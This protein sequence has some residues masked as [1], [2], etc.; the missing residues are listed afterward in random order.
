MPEYSYALDQAELARYDAMAARALEHE[1]DLWDTAGIITGAAV[2]DLGCGPGAFLAALATRTA[3]SGTVVG[4]DAAGPAIA[5]AQALVDQRS[6]SGRVRIVHAGAQHTGLEPASFDVVFIRNLLV[7]NGPA[8]GAILGHA[9][10]LLRPGGH[11][12]CAEPD[13][14][15]L[16][17]PGRAAAEQELEQCWIAMMRSMGNDPGLGAE[18]RLAGL[19][20]AAGFILDSEVHR[21]DSLEVERSPAWTARQMMA[22][23]GFAT[24]ADITRWDTAIAARLRDVGLL[25]CRLPVTAV[26]A[27]PAPARRPAPGPQAERTPVASRLTKPQ[28]RPALTDG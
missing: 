1:A 15:A 8:A 25:A 28:E 7:H 17:F 20:S 10:G 2:A 21:V 12:L 13:I 18:G 14:T 23:T 3:P 19:I 16:R 27:H 26:V 6:L 9:R 5:A 11:L 4:V 24:N 22:D